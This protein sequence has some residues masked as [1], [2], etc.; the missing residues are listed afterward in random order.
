[1]LRRTL[2]TRVTLKGSLAPKVF[3]VRRSPFALHQSDMHSDLLSDHVMTQKAARDEAVHRQRVL[4]QRGQTDAVARAEAEKLH[5][6]IAATPTQQQYNE[7][8]LI[9]VVLFCGYIGGHLVGHRYF[10][11]GDGMRLPY[12]PVN[13][14]IPD[15]ELKKK[16]NLKCD[17][18]MS[19]HVLGVVLSSKKSRP[20]LLQ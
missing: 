18:E 15:L 14:F 13:G 12:D 16:D 2:P 1:M 19:R 4:E 20:T 8:R 5:A 11:G 9:Y 3:S 10:A 6:D 17:A 7:I